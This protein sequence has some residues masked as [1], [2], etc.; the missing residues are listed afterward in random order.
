MAHYRKSA[1]RQA[2]A[3]HRMSAAL[4]RMLSNGADGS[5]RRAARWAAAWGVAS[6]GK[7]PEHFRLRKRG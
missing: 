6:G 5:K 4:D 2:Y 1:S 3:I 7:V